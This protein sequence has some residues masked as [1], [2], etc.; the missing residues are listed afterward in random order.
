MLFITD[1]LNGRSLYYS[2]LPTLTLSRPG[3]ADTP[4]FRQSCL[5]FAHLTALPPRPGA[6][7]PLPKFHALLQK[8]CD[9]APGIPVILPSNATDC[10]SGCPDDTSPR[11]RLA[12]DPIRD[13]TLAP[14]TYEDTQS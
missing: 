7:R 14:L 4:H 10:P 2:R 9:D 8:S 6:H 1:S 5:K 13:R 12:G 3:A 11:S